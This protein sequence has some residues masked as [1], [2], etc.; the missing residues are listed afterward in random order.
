MLFWCL[1]DLAGSNLFSCCCFFLF[2][3]LVALPPSHPTPL[4]SGLIYIQV[5]GNTKYYTQSIIYTP[6]F[7]LWRYLSSYP[8][9]NSHQPPYHSSLHFLSILL[10]IS[11]PP[12]PPPPPRP[13]PRHSPVLL[14]FQH[15]PTTFHIRSAIPPGLRGKPCPS[16]WRMGR[17]RCQG[18]SYKCLL[19][20]SPHREPET[21]TAATRAPSI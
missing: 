7:F 10:L 18:G 9:E 8:P 14:S 20:R 11:D 6:Y 19:C 2:F 13:R 3:S 12:P 5:P 15:S 17:V 16:V 21:V 1:R 4:P